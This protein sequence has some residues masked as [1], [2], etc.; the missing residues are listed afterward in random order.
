MKR[1]SECLLVLPVEM[2]MLTPKQWEGEISNHDAYKKG[3][4]RMDLFQNLRWMC[5]AET[6]FH[7]V[8]S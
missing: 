7:L 2:V 6:P 5:I 1:P 8:L 3:G 4:K